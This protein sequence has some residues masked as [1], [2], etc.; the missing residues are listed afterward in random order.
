MMLYKFRYFGKLPNST[1]FHK[2][3]KPCLKCKT[4]VHSN[5]DVF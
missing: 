1:P 4:A 2:G 5:I 3:N